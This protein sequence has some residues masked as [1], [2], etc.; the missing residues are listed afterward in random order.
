M[1]KLTYYGGSSVYVQFS[2]IVSLRAEDMG[3]GIFTL[4]SCV[5][6]YW[7]YVIE[8]PEQILELANA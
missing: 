5:G 7:V 2:S 3:N 1:L 4:V 6:S 8:T